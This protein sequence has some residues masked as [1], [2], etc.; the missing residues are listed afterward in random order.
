MVWG[1]RLWGFRAKG[2]GFGV[3]GFQYMGP[4]GL[5]DETS[6]AKGGVFPDERT[7]L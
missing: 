6:R 7:H 3:Q 2:L 1:F 5:G 4:I